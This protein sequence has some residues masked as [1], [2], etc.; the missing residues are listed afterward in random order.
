[1]NPRFFQFYYDVW[2]LGWVPRCF[3][4]QEELKELCPDGR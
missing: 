4:S 3:M 1:M 2:T